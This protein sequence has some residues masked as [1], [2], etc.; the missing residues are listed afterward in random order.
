[1]MPALNSAFLIRRTAGAFGG[2]AG[3]RV[4]RV[5]LPENAGLE[6]QEQYEHRHRTNH[7]HHQTGRIAGIIVGFHR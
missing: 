7:Q 4:C 1:M 3:S 5:S 6:D 2:Q